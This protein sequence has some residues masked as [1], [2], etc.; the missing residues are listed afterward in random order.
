MVIDVERIAKCRQ[1]I[2]KCIKREL[3][4]DPHHKSYEGS[5]DIHLPSMF[6]EDTQP[7]SYTLHCYVAPGGREHFFETIQDLETF[8]ID[9]EAELHEMET[10]RGD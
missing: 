9:W 2:F 10:V 3:K 5:M 4:I 6:T 7:E 8:I 1:R